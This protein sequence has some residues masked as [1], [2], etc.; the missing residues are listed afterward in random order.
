MSVV[1]CVAT[2]GWADGQFVCYYR[3]ANELSVGHNQGND[4]SSYLFFLKRRLKTIHP[5]LLL[6]TL[7]FGKPQSIHKD[8]EKS[9]T[10]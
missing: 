6:L 5:K 1:L 2:Q 3:L 10:M 8:E 7:G 4:D 9:S